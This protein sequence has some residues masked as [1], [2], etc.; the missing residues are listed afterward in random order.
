[1]Q[2]PMIQAQN[3][4]IMP[5]AN[6]TAASF[7]VQSLRKHVSALEAAAAQVLAK[8]RKEAVHRLRIAARRIEALLEVIATLGRKEPGFAEVERP[9]AKVKELLAAVRRAAGSVRDLDVQRRLAKEVAEGGATKKIRSEAKALRKQL[10]RDRDSDAKTLVTMLEAHALELEPRLEELMKALEPVTQVGL[11]PV[12]L[13][14][15]VRDW[16]KRRRGK[17]ASKRKA[18]DQMHG[19][20]KAAKLARYMAENGLA[21]RVVKEFETVQETGGRWHDTMTLR[22]TARER[23]GKRSGLAEAMER[24]EADARNEFVKLVAEA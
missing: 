24:R 1:L 4:L 21:A 10:G 16:Y 8:P 11:S 9:A 5:R 7:P 12:E 22:D 14:V 20:R 3:V 18:V 15:L 13:E 6:K 2:C 19:T 17:A 23:V